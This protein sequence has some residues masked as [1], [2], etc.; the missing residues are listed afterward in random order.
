MY[1]NRPL[2]D[3]IGDTSSRTPTPGG[4]SVSA[5]TGALGASLLCMVAN[6]TL[7]K[8]RYKEVEDEV[9]RLLKEVEE[10]REKLTRL[11]QEDIEAYEQVHQA[12]KASRGTSEKGK[13]YSQL[14]EKAFKQ[15]SSIPLRT[16]QLC[17]QLIKLGEKLLF[18]GNPNL[19]TDTGIGVL[20]AETALESAAL[21]VEINLAS[22]K[23]EE[24]KKKRWAELSSFL[25][26]G[27]RIRDGVIGKIK[28]RLRGDD[29]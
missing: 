16:A 24:F 4:G 12:I 15:A 9:K 25:S 20:L 8:K 1:L 14:L 29:L 6:F 19:I 2:K 28:N 26:E 3:F 13:D 23:D 18:I 10:L 7:G 21:N 5:L 27:K 22:I 17:L 11:I